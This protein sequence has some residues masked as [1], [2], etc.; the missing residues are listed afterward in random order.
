[1]APTRSKIFLSHLTR[2][3]APQSA[4]FPSII[5]VT[6]MLVDL[7]S[8]C[9][10]G[11]GNECMYESARAHPYNILSPTSSVNHSSL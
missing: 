11:T 8:R 3:D 4:I 7:R 9:T 1:M 5:F 6:R 10:I 2:R